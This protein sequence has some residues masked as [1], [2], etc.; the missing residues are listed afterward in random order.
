MRECGK[1]IIINTTNTGSINKRKLF[2]FLR[3]N[4][5]YFAMAHS[6]KL[7]LIFSFL[8]ISTISAFD[9][10]MVVSQYPP[11][12]CKPPRVCAVS[13]QLL[14]NTFL[15]YGAWPVDTTNPRTHLIADPN[16]PAFDV[17]Q[18]HLNNIFRFP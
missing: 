18:F 2:F 5:N 1:M 17:V 9:A 14:P 6:M 10:Y 7:I 3:E 8:F 11:T 4:E 12:V 16:A 15:L 13:L